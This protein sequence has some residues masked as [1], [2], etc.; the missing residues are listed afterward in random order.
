MLQRSPTYFFP[1][2]NENE[3]ADRCAP[4]RSTRRWIHEITRRKILHDQAEVTRLSF[5][6]PEDGQEAAHRGVRAYLGPDFD[7]EKH[8]TPRYRPW[9][10][11][12]AFVPD[13]DIF[14]G[15][16]SGKAS[17]VTDEIDRFTKTGLRLK[18]GE[19]LE[20]DIIVTATGFNL[21]VLGDIDFRDR[22][23]SRSTSRR[24]SPTAG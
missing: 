16:A 14:Q 11:R 13:G 18:S 7:V 5:E 22:R 4:S 20:A 9:Q 24:R 19:E 6:Q 2:R 15:I 3:L 10:Q 8:F 23:R 17:V 21:S 1:G 12:L